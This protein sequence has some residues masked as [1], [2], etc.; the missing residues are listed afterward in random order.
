MGSTP[1]VDHP[2]VKRLVF[3]RKL[4]A[5]R[6]MNDAPFRFLH[7]IAFVTFLYFYLTHVPD[8]SEAHAP[9]GNSTVPSAASSESIDLHG[10]LFESDELDTVVEEELSLPLDK[11][12]AVGE[13]WEPKTPQDYV[14]VVWAFI[15]IFHALINLFCVW[16]VRVRVLFQYKRVECLE[17]ADHVLCIPPPHHG[18]AGI[19]RLTSR[20]ITVVAPSKKATH[21]RTVRR[22]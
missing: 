7:I 8:V 13:L 10:P 6:C 12:P 3:L 9:S 19:T 4:P 20:A 1:D 5:L 14:R 11:G 22:R 18:D 21:C 17:E 16:M 2:H 15:A